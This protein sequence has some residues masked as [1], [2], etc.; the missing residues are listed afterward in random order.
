MLPSEPNGHH[1][2]DVTMRGWFESAPVA[3][4]R[5]VATRAHAA[6]DSGSE[7]RRARIAEPDT[8]VPTPRPFHP[9]VDPRSDPTATRHEELRSSAQADQGIRVEHAGDEL[10]HSG[11][12][13]LVAGLISWTLVIYVLVTRGVPGT[14]LEFVGIDRGHPVLWQVS[15]ALLW[16]TLAVAAFAV[17]RRLPD[18]PARNRRL[19]VL[20]ALVGFFQVALFVLA[21][22]ALSFG[23]SPYSHEILPMAANL[24]YVLTILVAVE[25]CRACIVVVIARWSATAALAV[26][27]VFFAVIGLPLAKPT[28]VDG[29][30][31]MTILVGERALPS[32]SEGLLASFLALVGGP[33]AAIAYRAVPTAFEWLSPILPDLSW[34]LTAFIGTLAPVL[35]LWII[36]QPILE[37]SDESEMLQSPEGGAAGGTRRRAGW[38]G[39]AVVAVTLIWFVTGMFGFQPVV[40]SGPSM[41]PTLEVGD[42]VVIQEA[43]PDEV[44][45]GD[46]IRFRQGGFQVIHRVVAIEDGGSQPIF[47]TRGDNNNTND[48]PVLAANLE[49]KVVLVVPNAGWPSVYLQRWLGGVT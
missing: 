32:L 4:R 37:M 22:L 41:N 46:I 3:R 48:A 5:S 35:G 30:E 20:A 11:D 15:H 38:L 28:S 44:E 8:S 16:S 14:L 47:M 36:Q 10:T 34:Q 9:A 13:R 25:M 7:R 23:R 19:I 39:V 42:M 26:A 27:T 33:L 24:L 31:S 18:R 40:V 45:V 2:R 17:W 6:A 1:D 12:L 43:S 29:V 21:G 49:G